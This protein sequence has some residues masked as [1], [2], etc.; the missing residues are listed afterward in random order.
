M[1][2]RRRVLGPADAVPFTLDNIKPTEVEQKSLDIG[3]IFVKTGVVENA[4][5]SAYLELDDIKIVAIVHGPRPMRG[6]FT[7]SAILNVDTKFLPVS[8]CD[9][10]SKSA[11][12]SST[13]LT[14]YIRSASTTQSSS[15]QKNVSS[16]VH[17]SLLPSILVEKYPKSTIDVS[18][19]VLSSSNN[20]KTTVA[21]AVSCAGAALADSGLECTDIVTAG[22]VL[23]DENKATVSPSRAPTSEID[24]VVS[25]MAASK[26]IVGMWIEG[27]NVSE[28][29]MEEIF[30]KTEEMAR[31]IRGVMHGVLL[32]Q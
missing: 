14:Q 30:D 18:I 25:Y 3:S 5:G 12:V 13:Q 7:T 19:S 9:I 6:L 2:D 8:L 20:T 16:Y 24:G 11:V 28:K 1:T 27:G 31:E 26:K 23:L 21:A 22:S 4:N 17:T 29:Q 10:E 32:E 15:L